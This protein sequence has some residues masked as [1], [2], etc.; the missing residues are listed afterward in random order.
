[1]TKRI[2]VTGA[3]GFIG[4][5]LVQ[6]LIDDGWSVIGASRHRPQ[7]DAGVVDWVEID[8]LSEDPA[9][10]V[11][12]ARAAALVHLAWIATPGLYASSPENLDWL[13]ASTELSAS[14]LDSGGRRLVGVGTGLE[15]DV[16][17]GQHATGR[18]L[19]ARAKQA[20]RIAFERQVGETPGASFAWAR[21]FYLLGS[22]DHPDRF[23]PSLA[24]R[25]AA[26]KPAEM[27]Q[28]LVERDFIDVRDCA[29][30]LAGL[31]SVTAGGTFD[32]ATGR[33]RR[34]RDLADAIA[35]ASGHP[36]LLHVNPALDRPSEPARLVGDP[37]RLAEA[38]GVS[39]I[40]SIDRS[41][42]D[43]IQRFR[44]ARG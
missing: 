33:G 6:A 40:Y 24:R 30:A 43:L 4:R 14:F 8:L 31:A 3:S 41:I 12:A 39:P 7:H 26:G 28:G 37:G 19:Y 44:E 36:Q 13:R 35:L 2:L 38:T 23:A 22:E 5:P 1:M 10:L 32:I 29:R 21:V 9:R 20:C 17:R 25:L 16:D 11:Q 18:T 15:Y 34:L 27:S 42:A